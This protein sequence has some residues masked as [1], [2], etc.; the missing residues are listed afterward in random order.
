MYLPKINRL[1]S[2]FIHHDSSKAGDA[3]VSITNTTKLRS[4]DGPS[5]MVEFERIGR[6]YHL[7]HFACDRQDELRELNAAYGAAHPRTA[8]GVSDDE[9]AAIVTA[10]LVAFMERQYEAIQTSVD[11]SHG[12]DQAMAYIRD[13]R[14]EQWRPPAGIHSIT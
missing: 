12:L 5:Y 11:C 13:I 9:T 2:A 7:Y 4:V 10:A 6:R 14:L 8:F 1:W 3:A